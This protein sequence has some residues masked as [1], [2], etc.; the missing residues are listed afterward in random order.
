LSVLSYLPL[1]AARQPQVNWG[2]PSTAGRF[3]WVVSAKAFHKALDKAAA[4][5]VEHRGSGAV[6]AVLGGLGPVAAL[7]SLGG[8]YLLLRCRSSWKVG[9]LLLSLVGF[10]LLSPLT[11]GFDPMNPDAHGYLAVAVAFL[12]PGLAVMVAAVGAVLARRRTWAAALWCL[13]ACGLPLY[14][15]LASLPRCDL[16]DHWAAEETGRMVLGPQ[17]GRALLVSSYFE[18]AFNLMALRAGADMRPDVRLL[19][20][21][22]LGMPGYVEDLARD[23][24]QLAA[25]ARRWRSAG[26]LLTTDLDRLARGRPLSLEYDLTLAPQVAARLRPAGLT[27]AYGAGPG[28]D[29]ARHL[30][31]IRRWQRALGPVDELETRRTVTWTHYLLARYACGQG[32]TELARFHHA[33]ASALAPESRDLARLASRCKLR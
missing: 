31:L 33:A 15:G 9:L 16:R 30:A 20:R 3:A 29:P 23:A 21:G 26:R 24:P 6:F 10:N 1:R 8:I 28:A 18:T 2:S 11:V 14:Q 27:L 13:L 25:A 5:T 32:D 4:E 17:P 12:G 19:H 22:F 7:L